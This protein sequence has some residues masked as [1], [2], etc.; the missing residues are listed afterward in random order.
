MSAR[1]RRATGGNDSP[2]RGRGCDRRSMSA[3]GRVGARFRV[4][5]AP[6]GPAPTT[7]TSTS[8]KLVFEPMRET[9]D[10]LDAGQINPIRGV[11]GIAFG[12]KPCQRVLGHIFYLEGRRKWGSP[13]PVRCSITPISPKFAIMLLI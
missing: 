10:L 11:R 7:R 13:G 8:R 3:T 9:T 12:R 2:M 4:A 1:S 6:A 5:V